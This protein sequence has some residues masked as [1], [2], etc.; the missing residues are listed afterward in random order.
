M[1]LAKISLLASLAKGTLWLMDKAKG[2]RFINVMHGEYIY[3]L[4]IRR[5][6]VAWLWLTK[7]PGTIIKA[8]LD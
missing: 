7:K 4:F 3:R 5:A 6:S 1:C 8:L 2:V